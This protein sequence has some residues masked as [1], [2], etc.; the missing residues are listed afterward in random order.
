M[1]IKSHLM[2]LVMASSLALGACD[3][4]KSSN[5]PIE[6]GDKLAAFNFR[7]TSFDFGKIQSGDTVSHDFGFVNTG[8]TPL[9]ISDVSATCGC[10][11]VNWPRNPIMPQQSGNIKIQFSKRHDPGQHSKTAIIKANT[12]G[13]YTVLRIK[14][15][16][17]DAGR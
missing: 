3:K 1:L 15:L 14:A 17:S 6:A 12:V 4:S 2:P 7:E 11:A 8:N 13:A 5:Q 9:L 10:T 16:V